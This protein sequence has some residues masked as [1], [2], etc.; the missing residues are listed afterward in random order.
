VEKLSNTKANSA[1]KFKARVS[2]IWGVWI[3]GRGPTGTT[4]NGGGGKAECRRGERTDKMNMGGS[5]HL[6][7]GSCETTG[8]DMT[9]P[10]EGGRSLPLSE[11]VGGGQRAKSEKE[12]SKRKI[13]AAQHKRR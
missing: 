2:R 10:F 12:K 7:G 1:R 5:G 4:A 8:D 6:W 11:R 9:K 3:P 13:G